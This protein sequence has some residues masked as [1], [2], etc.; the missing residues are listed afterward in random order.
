MTLYV[1]HIYTLTKQFW[2]LMKKIRY[3]W[4][5]SRLPPV[6]SCGSSYDLQHGLPFEKGGFL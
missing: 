1:A 6:Y 5:S 3:R 4:P 2:D